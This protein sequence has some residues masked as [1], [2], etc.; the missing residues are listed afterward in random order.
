[1]VSIFLNQVSV[2]KNSK[3]L[4]SFLNG[5]HRLVWDMM[6]AQWDSQTARHVALQETPGSR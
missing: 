1:M 6:S 2:L 4:F 5:H 3:P